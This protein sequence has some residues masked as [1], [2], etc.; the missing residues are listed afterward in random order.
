MKFQYRA[1]GTNFIFNAAPEQVF[2]NKASFEEAYSAMLSLWSYDKSSVQV[3]CGDA[4]ITE[5]FSG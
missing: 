5:V 2:I 1:V 3:W 4:L